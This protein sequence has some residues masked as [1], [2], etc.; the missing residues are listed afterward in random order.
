V[1]RKKRRRMS[2]KRRRRWSH[3]LRRERKMKGQR[4]RETRRRRRRRV[5]M[6]RRSLLEEKVRVSYLS[7]MSYEIK[8]T[9]TKHQHQGRLGAMRAQAEI[10]VYMMPYIGRLIVVLCASLLVL[11]TVCVRVAAGGQQFGAQ[12]WVKGWTGFKYPKEVV[13]KPGGWVVRVD[14]AMYAAV[15]CGESTKGGQ[16]QVVGSISITSARSYFD[17]SDA[18]PCPRG[19]ATMTG[20]QT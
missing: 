6:W 19:D 12:G 13:C 4:K 5:R 8:C 15:L 9:V 1:R 17:P 11:P 3:L 7:L 14:D 16:G 10:G 2:Q 18:H 20:V